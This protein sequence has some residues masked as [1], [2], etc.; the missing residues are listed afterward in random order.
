MSNDGAAYIAATVVVL[1]ALASPVAYVVLNRIIVRTWATLEKIYHERQLR[2]RPVITGAEANEETPLVE[3][4]KR[5]SCYTLMREKWKDSKTPDFAVAELAWLGWEIATHGPEDRT[6]ADCA[7]SRV[8]KLWTRKWKLLILTSLIIFSLSTFGL[9]VWGSIASARIVTSSAALSDS[10]DCGFWIP[11][12]K[13]DHHKNGT[14]GFLYLQEVEAGEYAKNCYGAA[15]G[16]DG[17]NFFASQDIPYT[18]KENDLCPFSDELC[19][20]GRSSAFTM[21]TPLISSKML[22]INV[23]T[24]YQFNRTTSCA[25]IKRDGFV[26]E[27][28]DTYDY[29]YGPVPGSGMP[30][31][32]SP[33]SSVRDFPGY[34]VAC[35]LRLLILHHKLRLTIYCNSTFCYEEAYTDEWTPLP[36][37]LPEK[38]DTT[39]LLLIQS[40]N[41]YHSSLRHDP[42][43]PAES[44]ID[45]PPLTYRPLYYNK[46]PIATILACVDTVS[47]CSAD[48]ST[49]W[50]DI[51]HP[52]KDLSSHVEKTGY[53]MLDIA[54]MRSNVC[55]SIH[56]RGGS[57]LDAHSKLPSNLSLPISLPLA[58]EQWKVEARK[59][60]EGSLARIQ[61]DLR[62]YI[63]GA[64]ANQRGFANHLDSAYEDMCRTYKFHTV[65]W[66]NVN[67]W[68]LR[69]LLVLVLTVYLLSF[70]TNRFSEEKETIAESIWNA[71]V[72]RMLKKLLGAKN[73]VEPGVA[74]GTNVA[75]GRVS[76]D[77]RS[78]DIPRPD[79]EAS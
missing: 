42:I 3:R 57:A 69:L 33:K 26:I 54:L 16:A 38:Y 14:D 8:R 59:L 18:V 12:P 4:S 27:T 70:E 30:T 62:D 71:T 36:A 20:E 50:A 41:N 63:R 40:Q 48:G 74:N 56:L 43:F 25:P 47:V 21:S 77:P 32:R 45:P 10:P 55:N 64:A 51:N 28:E 39:T 6:K 68:A 35:V 75:G 46:D 22:G 19:L 65:G 15:R 52:T 11:D 5:R 2:T 44:E 17:C 73:A 76:E 67:L 49:C 37:F 34:H 1:L 66:K 72:L 23:P 60:F 24:G 9:F 58:T 61:I 79:R 31:W 78:P 7:G 13:A 29:Y 53:Y